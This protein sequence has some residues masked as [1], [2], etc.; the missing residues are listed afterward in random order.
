MNFS[1]TSYCP[2]C[3]AL[4]QGHLDLNDQVW[5]V[6]YCPRHG[7]IR[8]LL[9]E[10]L[11][12]FRDALFAADHASSQPRD[13]CVVID[14]TSRCDVGCATCSASSTDV[15]SD[16]PL[17]RFAEWTRE[18]TQKTGAR[19]IALSGGEPLMRSDIIELIDIAKQAA[20][21]VI[22]I[23]SG[24]GFELETGRLFQEFSRR[25]SWL[26]IYLQFDS[27]RDEVL[28]K[29]RGNTMTG[30]LRRQRLET[31]INA[32]VNLSAVCV[33][34]PESNGDEIPKII[35]YLMDS[36]ASGVT[37]QPLRQLGRFP[38]SREM[39]NPLST[40]DGLQRVA[41]QAVGAQTQPRPFL[42]QPFDIS[43]SWIKN[44]QEY[45]KSKFFMVDSE[46][47]GFRI[48][49]SS[50]W[51]AT[52]YFEPFSFQGPFY[53]FMMNHSSNLA[54]LNSHYLSASVPSHELMKFESICN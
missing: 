41:L 50:Y 17:L 35:S 12:Y 33:I 51:D 1:G 45:Q 54:P 49:T 36:G 23:T 5:L 13:T 27:L 48:A 22:L 3:H 40:V 38:C 2:E 16:L 32:G 25:S 9:F 28:A 14:V 53:F 8:T 29:L 21:K 39:A 11:D 47:A 43:V 6:R 37:F 34:D 10:S 18:V 52:N 42:Q 44:G 20:D 46:D 4:L 7:E 30:S 26:E 19:T 31:A 15:G 24:R